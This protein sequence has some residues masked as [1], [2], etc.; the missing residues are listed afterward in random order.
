MR[1][2]NR[3]EAEL[4]GQALTN[5]ATGCAGVDH[6]YGS[7]GSRNHIPGLS[8][9]RLDGGTDGDAEIN[10]WANRLE[11]GNLGSKGRHFRRRE[12]WT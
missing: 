11:I 5:D 7:D 12:G 1:D 3:L 10:D 6:R 8:K 4:G 2:S 9:G